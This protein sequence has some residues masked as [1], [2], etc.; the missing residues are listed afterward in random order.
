MSEHSGT[1]WCERF[2]ESVS[3]DDLA[4]PFKEGTMKFYAALIAAHADVKIACTY[5]PPERAYLMHFACMIAS[6]QDPAL[7]PAHDGVDIDW[8]CG[9]N[10]LLARQN[11]I[12]MRTAYGIVFPAALQS[13]HTQ[14]LAVDWNITWQAGLVVRDATGIPVPIKSLSTRPSGANAKDLWAV[15]K[16]YGVIKLATDAP[17]WSVDGH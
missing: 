11:A 7:V 5:R 8:T 17:H 13:R 10:V 4:E 1:Q 9:G 12:Y 15:G 3:L 14:R 6:G 16:T 2:P